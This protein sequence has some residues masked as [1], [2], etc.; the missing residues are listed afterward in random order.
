MLGSLGNNGGQTDSFPLLSGSP[1]IDRGD[2][3]VHRGGFGCGITGAFYDLLYDQRKNRLPTGTG[4]DIGAYEAGSTP[5]ASVYTNS[6]FFG[7][8]QRLFGSKVTVTDVETME[9]QT[10]FISMWDERQMREGGSRPFTF[11][12]NGVYVAEIRSKRGNIYNPLIITEL[13]Y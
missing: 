1:A 5:N 7:R 12:A 13:G 6:L 11:R 2:D 4:I 10:S 8:S 9:K 3:C